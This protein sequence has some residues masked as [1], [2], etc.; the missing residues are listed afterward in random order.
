MVKLK[1][2]F[3]QQGNLDIDIPHIPHIPQDTPV[4]QQTERDRERFLAVA[5]DLQ[6][7]C[8]SNGY[9]HWVNPTFER[10]L[11][12]TVAEITSRPW[13][14]FIHPDD[15]SESI[16]E[17]SQLFSGRETL[18]FENRLRHKD[19]SYHWLL[20]RAQ[21]YPEEQVIYATAVDITE[22]KVAE[23]ALEQSEQKFRAIFESMFQFIGVLTPEGI[24]VEA[25]QTALDAVGI[26]RSEVIGKLFW[27]TP[28][29][30]HSPVL[31][32]QLQEAV[33]RARQGELVRFEAE[34]IL[35]N[36]QTAFVDFSLKPFFD[37][38]GNVVMLIP[39][40]RDITELKQTEVA[41]RESEQRL[42]ALLDNSTAIIFMKDA[43]GRY[44]IINRSYETLFHLDR[45]QV[46]GKTDHDIFPKEIADAFQANDR[47]VITS[48]VAIEKEEIA[49]RDDG[50]H[51]YLSLKFPLF[52]TTGVVYAVC[53]IATD[54]SERK[55]IEN[56]RKQ[57]AIEL[58][59]QKQDL[60]RSNAELQQFAYVA[61]HDL[62]E[63]LRMVTSYLELLKRRYAGQLDEKA[64]QFIGFAVDGA[65]RMQTLIND[66]LAY[67]R[68][69]T[70]D[71]PLEPVD[72]QRI[73]EN[74][75]RNLQ[76]TI[77]DSQGKITHDPLP[78][79][80]V[81]PTQLAQLF[82]NL[83]SNGIKFR[84][85]GVS[86]HIHIGCSPHGNKWLFS[87]QDNGI[88]IDP[89]YVDRIFLIFQR[90]HSRTEYPGTGIGLAVCKKIVE[91]YSGNLWVESKPGQ[92]STF[93]FTIPQ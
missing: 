23:M 32:T 10:S 35:A 75:L 66:L 13:I 67:S 64:E 38:A 22:R 36:G 62:Q 20:W 50:L 21:P 59:L 18:A 39:E 65:A 2:N 54:I 58:Q 73:L 82:Q 48:G 61:S 17:T 19:G 44:V 74:V 30:I 42:Q 3:K 71:Q 27:Q 91:R 78:Q 68:V 63:P 70:H 37:K 15:V 7:I 87:I 33:E 83:L 31:Q 47:E 57:T 12:W 76:M 90:L 8:G 40:G 79:V 49:P 56:E 55:R 92:G 34:H 80:Q 4:S 60:A 51:T 53:G 88:G 93:Y 29:W 24:L 11:G 81:D 89:Q 25:N 16:T 6:V 46:K 5:S 69:G 77:A 43:Q 41:F 1:N 86:P 28:W 26:Q 14:E 9:F 84:Q 72:C 85:P 52:D 45:N